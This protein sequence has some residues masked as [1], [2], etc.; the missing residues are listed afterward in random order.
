MAFMNSIFY[1]FSYIFPYFS[2]FLD[3]FLSIFPL[4]A[5]T[6]IPIDCRVSYHIIL[7][8]FSHH[9]ALFDTTFLLSTLC[10]HMDPHSQ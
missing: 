4:A 8:S 6:N 2:L 1:Y 7:T 3:I 9:I 5:S 10:F